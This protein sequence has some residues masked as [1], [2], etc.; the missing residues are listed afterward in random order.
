MVDFQQIIMI[1]YLIVE[2]NIDL[3]TQSLLLIILIVI[4]DRDY[5]IVNWI[6]SQLKK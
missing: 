5:S 2:S 6:K 4:A 3:H 1:M